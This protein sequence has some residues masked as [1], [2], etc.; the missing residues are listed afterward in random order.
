MQADRVGAVGRSSAENARRRSGR[1]SSGLSH[2][3]VPA[4]AVEPGQH[5]HLGTDVQVTKALSDALGEDQP[6][7]GRSLVT[8][9]RSLVAVDQRRHHPP[10]WA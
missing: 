10:D 7:I 2:E 9:Q 1:V 8:L 6:G 3:H 5:Q 4:G